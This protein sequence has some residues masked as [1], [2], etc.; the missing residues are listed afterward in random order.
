ME[1]FT[2]QINPAVPDLGIEY[3]AHQAHVGDRPWVANGALQGTRGESRQI[4]GFA[5]RLTGAR[6]SNY[7]VCYTAHV[8]DVGDTAIHE[9]GAYCGTRGQSRRIEGIHVWIRRA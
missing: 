3:M 2:L 5:V 6:A 1:A 9:N 4:E 8:A 7:V